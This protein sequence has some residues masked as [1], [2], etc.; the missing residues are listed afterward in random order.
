MRR[1]GSTNLY[2]VQSAEELE[3]YFELDQLKLNDTPEEEQVHHL[4][5]ETEDLVVDEL[6]GIRAEGIRLPGGTIMTGIPAESAAPILL[7]S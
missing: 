3:Q 1:E 2:A 6:Y 5:V 7:P 4:A